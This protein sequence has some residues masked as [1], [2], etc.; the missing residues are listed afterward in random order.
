MTMDLYGHLIDQNLWDAAKEIWGHHGGTGRA[1]PGN[2]KTPGRGEWVLTWGFGWSRLS[3]SNRRPSH[4]EEDLQS[5]ICSLPA[6][7]ATRSPASGAR[8]PMRTH[9]FVPRMM[10]RMSSRPGGQFRWR[11]SLGESEGDRAVKLLK[12]IGRG[13]L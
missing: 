2:Y 10:P 6:L 3:E 7:L 1:W 4:Y 13:R 11:S 8:F 9:S 12:V 5:R